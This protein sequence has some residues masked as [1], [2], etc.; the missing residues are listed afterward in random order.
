MEP[1]PGE[2]ATAF[3]SAEGPAQAPSP[4]DGFSLD[5]VS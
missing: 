2:G 5:T 3:L 1:L 4:C